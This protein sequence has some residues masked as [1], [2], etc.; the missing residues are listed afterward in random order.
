[1]NKL[2]VFWGPLWYLYLE[3]KHSDQLS[4]LKMT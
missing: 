1:M 2:W 4:F 3:H